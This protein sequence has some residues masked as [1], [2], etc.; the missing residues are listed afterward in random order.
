MSRWGKISLF[1]SGLA[2]I[3][4]FSVRY[5]MDGWQN[6]MF[7]PLAIFLIGIILA[8][9]LEWRL[10]LDFFSMRTTKHGMN[11][12]A[13]IVL[14]IVLLVAVNFLSV[15]MNKTFDLTEE[16]INSL[17]PQTQDVLKS[18]QGDVKVSVFYKGED[19]AAPNSAATPESKLRIKQNFE[20]YQEASPKVKVQFYNTYTENLKA[21]EYLSQLPDKQRS[22][23]FVFV[24]YNGKKARVE[25]PFGE[26]QI[27]SALIQSTKTSNKKI[28]FLQG[29]GERSLDSDEADGLKLFK[30]SLEQAAFQVAPLN[31]LEKGAIPEDAAVVA[32]VG[33]LSQL[34]D[35]EI[36]ALREF[37][38]KGGRL[39]IAADPGQR[40]N[41]AL[42]TKPLGV[43]FMNNY[44][45][46]QKG[47]QG[48]SQAS[49]LGLL[50]D[51]NDEI[52]KRFEPGNSLTIFDLASELR[53]APNKPA[54]IKAVE[55]VK[56]DPTSFAIQ[57]LKQSQ[58]KPDFKSMAIGIK[59]SGDLNAAPGKP[60]ED[61]KP[62]EFEAIVFGD[63]D[64]VSNNAI[65]FGSNR[66]LAV[67]SIASLAD[68]SVLVSIRPPMP[69]GTKVELTRSAALAFIFVSFAAP[70]IILI[71]GAVLWF[72]RRS[73]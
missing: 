57:E 33:A 4:L 2:L 18:L 31:L 43:E 60:K 38:K 11:M 72:R 19:A 39:F 48:R 52:T 50:Y 63:S 49:T 65:Q 62:V 21:D 25:S 45:I 61:A 6:F 51:P 32:I 27:T 1:L 71:S 47:V 42:L 54:T 59:V 68:E 73:A 15:R 12:G 46:N 30:Q 24:E 23:I 22:Q 35:N 58:V 13:M 10:F 67:N 16:K 8:L 37:T 66:D 28:Y 70:I 7:V 5:L 44:I 14:A 20:P 55:L 53:I 9:A 40:H 64:F 29:H 26:E 56:T 69:K 36:K 34:I 17:S 3:I 41:L